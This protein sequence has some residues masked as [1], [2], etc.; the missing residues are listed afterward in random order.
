L[1]PDI[2]SPRKL[3]AGI[4]LLMIAGMLT[5]AGMT[6][7][8]F[9]RQTIIDREAAVVHD[10]INALVDQHDV[11][12]SDMQDYDDPAAR[13][14]LE[15]SFATLRGLRDVL[16]V[17]VFN[18]DRVIVWSDDPAMVGTRRTLH[19]NDLALALAG[20]VRAVFNQHAY[21]S[22]ILDTGPQRPDSIEFYMPLVVPGEHEAP[23]QIVGALAVYRAPEQLSE[24]LWNGEVRIGAVVGGA[25][26]LL[27]AALYTLFVAVHSK[28]QRIE[29]QFSQLSADQNRLVQ[30]EKMSAMGELVGQ[31]A[32]QLNNPLIGVLNMSQLAEREADN[33]QRVR[34]LLAE[35]KRGGSECRD[36]IQRILRLN[37]SSKSEP[38]RVNLVELIH[39]TITFCHQTLHAGER[40]DFITDREELMMEVDPVLMRHAVFNLI[41]NAVLAAPDQT[42]TVEFS[43][44]AGEGT[45]GVCISVTDRGPG[46]SEEAQRKLFTPFFTTRSNGTGLGLPVARHIAMKHGGQLRGTNQPGGGA[47]FSIWLPSKAQP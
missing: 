38:Q 45:P 4:S 11:L 46:L 24:A 16:R 17:K 10:M 26:L 5:A 22:V 27:F 32:H 2:A 47:R 43:A 8:A 44:E 20:N 25:G 14:R 21:P 39:D 34:E 12:T 37:R 31:I 28:Q 7:A 9:F 6:A 36:I 23:G 41:H 3:F 30:L 15:L 33:P 35:V 1:L 19:A 40:I 29:M 42:V 18:R 13:K